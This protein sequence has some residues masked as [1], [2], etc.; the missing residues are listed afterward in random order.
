VLELKHFRRVS[1]TG[2]RSVW[3]Q[4]KGVRRGHFRDVERPIVE[5]GIEKSKSASGR[6]PPKKAQKEIERQITRDYCTVLGL[7]GM[8]KREE[9]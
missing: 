8:T 5:N 6:T 9:A 7:A 2:L 4:S 3:A 1:L